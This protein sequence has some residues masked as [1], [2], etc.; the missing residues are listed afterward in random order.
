LRILFLAAALAAAPLTWAQGPC[1]LSDASG[2]DCADGTNDCDLL[3]DMTVAKVLLE[4]GSANPESPGELGVS[5]SSPNIGHGP[6]RIV[7]TDW[8]VCGTDTI[9]S[10]GGYSGLCPD[11]SEPRQL[12]QQRIYH[13]NPDGSMSFYDRWAGSMTYHASHGHMHVD[14][15]GKYSLRTEVPGLDPIDWPIVAEGAK[16]GFCLMDYGSCNYYNGHCVDQAGNVLTTDAPNYGLGGGSYSCGLS[17]QGI[18]AGY[19]DIYYYY[20]DGMQIPIPG[21]VCNGTYKL[22]VHLD[23]Y[24]YFLEEDE[25]NNVVAVDITLT[26][27][28]GGSVGIVPDGPT[29]FCE[30]G[31]VTLALDGPAS[32]YAWSTG[33]TTP[34]ITVDAT[35]TVTCTAVT[36]CGTQTTPP[37][38]VVVHPAAAPVAEADTS[39]GP[40]AVT[41]SAT[42][43]GTIRWY[44]APSGGTPL[45]TGSSYT[46]PPL[47]ASTTYWVEAENGAPGAVH[48]VG[49]TGHAGTSA[50]NGTTINSYLIFDALSAFTLVSVQVETDYPGTRLIE[51]R[52]SGGSVLAS[53]S[54]SIP[55]GVSRVTLDFEVPAGTNLQ[56]GSNDAV[57]LANFGGISPQVKRSASGV[58]MPYEVPGVVRVHDT[59]YGTS[60]WYYWYDWEVREPGTLCVSAR[61]PVEAVVDLAC[62]GACNAPAAPATGGITANQ[63]TVSWTGN[64]GDL[65]YQVQ[66]RKAG[67]A[68][69]R[70]VQLTGTSYTVTGLKPATA[71]EWYVRARCADG[72]T[73]PFTALQSFT[74]AAPRAA[75]PD[76]RLEPNP[77]AGA[78]RVVRSAGPAVDVTVEDLLG[79]VRWTG[80]SPEGQTALTVDAPLGAGLYLVR[81]RGSSGEG[82][83][84]LVVE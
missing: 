38:D 43:T 57:N 42:A 48:A 76:F 16:L 77:A 65:G 12:I 79:R 44:D 2:C 29:A 50:Y 19:T 66:G 10:P 80:R 63:A 26:Q 17:N 56:L 13:K 5:V 68:S 8:F 6:L 47:A 22:V 52:N 27:Q 69:F 67:T 11:G 24:D 39:C 64:A 35:E 20:L 15:W 78:F 84:R 14:D 54:V 28:G 7:A 23:P 30:G 71:Y 49:P 59:P 32:S 21:S 53:R 34:T 18:S 81:L 60:Y 74:T 46:T 82:V 51:L 41:L 58:S 72:S 36:T 40:G 70:Q 25:T 1:N 33:E 83:Q 45:A 31:S 62:G 55:A 3:P 61:E 9:L 37:V 73:T 4:D 75:A